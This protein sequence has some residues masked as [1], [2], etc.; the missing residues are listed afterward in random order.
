[1]PLTCPQTY[2]DYSDDRATARSRHLGLVV[3]VFFNTLS[4]E[5]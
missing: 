1:M 3:S 4:N 5:L 2:P